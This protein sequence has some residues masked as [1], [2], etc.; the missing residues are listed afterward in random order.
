MALGLFSTHRGP[1]K[2]LLPGSCSVLRQP[3]QIARHCRLGF[4]VRGGAVQVDPMLMLQ[5]PNIWD[6]HRQGVSGAEAML[7]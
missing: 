5:G 2:G 3:E 4:S 6:T 7:K 1:H